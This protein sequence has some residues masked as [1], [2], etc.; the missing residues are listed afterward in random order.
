MLCGEKIRQLSSSS[1]GGLSPPLFVDETLR[2]AGQVV[3]LNNPACG[4]MVL[5]ALGYG[6]PWL[7][8]LATLG[9]ASATASA[10]ALSL[11]AGMISAGLAG[12]NGCLVG[13]AAAAVLGQPAWS[14]SFG[15]A[16]AT[17][18]GAA[19]TAP[20]AATLKPML[21]RVPQFTWAFNLTTLAVLGSLV[22][23]LS[24]AAAPDPT[25]MISALEWACSPLVGISQIFVVNDPISGAMLIGAIGL[26]SPACAAHTLL[27]SSVGVATALACGA[28]ATE[29]GMGL[30]GYNSALT[31]LAVSVFF[32]ASPSSYA[33]AGS[34]AAATALLFGASKG[35]VASAIASPVLTLPFCV[36]ASACHLMPHVVP[37]LVHAAD[38]HS[39]EK[40]EPPK[41]QTPGT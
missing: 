23:P 9:T 21:G 16:A 8:V 39:P 18:A 17:V 25:T 33:L 4:A 12:Y 29:I 35:A 32:V 20:L 28:P 37:T 11:D 10:R 31:A 22:R 3:F 15:A 27:G 26:Y 40:N 6:D 24:S 13:C 19:V 30:W 5:G 1:V 7:G 41:Q 14:W 36:V 34:G 2:G 38:P